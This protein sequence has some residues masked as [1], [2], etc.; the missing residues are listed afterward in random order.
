[1]KIDNKWIWMWN[2]RGWGEKRQKIESEMK[3]PVKYQVWYGKR[4]NINFVVKI[5]N[6]RRKTIKYGNWGGKHHKI[7]SLRCKDLNFE[8]KML[9]MRLKVRLEVPSWVVTNFGVEHVGD[10][11]AKK[12]LSQNL[13]EPVLEVFY[14]IKN[15]VWNTLRSKKNPSLSRLNN[16]H[17]AHCIKNSSF[18]PLILILNYIHN[19]SSNI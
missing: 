3:N 15:L 13:L 7:S 19:R 4:S 10:K 14:D 2:Y 12:K 18:S 16:S 8:V 9:S 6:L 17:H 1:M 5:S 11:N